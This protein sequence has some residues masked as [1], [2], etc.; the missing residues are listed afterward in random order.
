MKDCYSFIL[1]NK[2]NGTCNREKTVAVAAVAVGGCLY[3]YCVGRTTGPA[4]VGGVW[5]GCVRQTVCA[6]SRRTA[7]TAPD[8][9]TSFPTRIQDDELPSPCGRTVAPRTIGR[10]HHCRRRRRVVRTTVRTVTMEGVGVAL[11]SECSTRHRGTV[12]PHTST[13]LLRTGC[14]TTPW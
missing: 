2:R 12:S 11:R 1:R 4:L 7:A 10:P 3:L 8:A 5:S 9:R 14:D 13:R 6:S